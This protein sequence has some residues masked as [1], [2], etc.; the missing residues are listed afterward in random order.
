MNDALGESEEYFGNIEDSIADGQP[1]V[2]AIDR[3]TAKNNRKVALDGTKNK[4]KIIDE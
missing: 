2:L 3:K 1:E 4:Y